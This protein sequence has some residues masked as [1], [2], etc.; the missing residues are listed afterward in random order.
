MR[1][2][3]HLA[4]SGYR[5]LLVGG[6][7]LYVGGWALRAIWRAGHPEFKTRGPQELVIHA[8]MWLAAIVLILAAAWAIAARTTER[9]YFIVLG[10]GA[11]NL[12]AELWHAW[13]HYHYQEYS[14]AHGLIRATAI[15]GVLAVAVVLVEG[16]RPQ[17]RKM[18]S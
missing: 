18:T 14:L 17:R 9:G 12:A 2:G 15:V 5:R 11:M 1:S 8:P 4:A 6:S 7:S 10:A 13:A 3:S 16:R